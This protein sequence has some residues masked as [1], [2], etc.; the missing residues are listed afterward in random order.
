[1]PSTPQHTWRYVKIQHRDQDLINRRCRAADSAVARPAVMAIPVARSG[2]GKS[3]PTIAKEDARHSDNWRSRDSEPGGITGPRRWQRI[4]RGQSRTTARHFPD[5]GRI[6]RYVKTR[7]H[8]C[9]E[10]VD[11]RPCSPGSGDPGI[12]GSPVYAAEQRTQRSISAPLRASSSRIIRSSCWVATMRT[13]ARSGSS[14][15]AHCR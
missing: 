13:T 8:L 7:P 15:E 6:E 5:K 11:L 4:H 12:Q 9:P 14:R 10:P 2:V 3:S 1:M